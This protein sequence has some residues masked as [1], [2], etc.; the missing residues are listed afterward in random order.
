M[1]E[2]V[3]HPTAFLS[4][5]LRRIN[6]LDNVLLNL[7]C[8]NLSLKFIVI[9]SLQ[10]LLAAFSNG[11]HVDAFTV[12]KTSHLVGDAAPSSVLTSG[13]ESPVN[14]LAKVLLELFEIPAVHGLKAELFL[15]H[16]VDVEK[17]GLIV[18]DVNDISLVSG[19]DNGVKS[20]AAL[21]KC[22]HLVRS[23]REALEDKLVS[24]FDAREDNGLE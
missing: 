3:K 22:V 2:T 23:L 12:S 7:N 9:R 24:V 19:K 1:G 21:F 5:G 8:G 10:A 16:G 6:H 17:T 4:L 18:A 14:V 20:R 15:E 11:I 13:Y